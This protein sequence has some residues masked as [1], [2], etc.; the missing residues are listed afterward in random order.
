MATGVC[1]NFPANAGGSQPLKFTEI[2][3]FEDFLTWFKHEES[4]SKQP[5]KVTKPT[6]RALLPEKIP[7]LK[8]EGADSVLDLSL[9]KDLFNDEAEPLLESNNAF[10]FIDLF[11]EE[12]QTTKDESKPSFGAR[13][14][15]DD[16]FDKMDKYRFNEVRDSIEGAEFT[17]ELKTN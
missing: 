13:V 11:S 8:K 1:I 10:N 6:E 16:N 15:M 7:A 2:A 4:K 17:L 3:S 9:P 14:I 12:N 5:E